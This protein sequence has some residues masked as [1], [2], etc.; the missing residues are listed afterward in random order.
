MSAAFVPLSC[1][2]G[3]RAVELQAQ[4]GASLETAGGGDPVPGDFWD[5]KA[6]AWRFGVSV[7]KNRAGAWLWNGRIIA[8]GRAADLVSRMEAGLCGWQQASGRAA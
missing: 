6:R 3:G 7:V 4:T 2:A 8:A 1:P 5:V